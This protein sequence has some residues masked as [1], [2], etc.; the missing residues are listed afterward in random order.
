MPKGIYERKHKG[1]YPRNISHYA[2]AKKRGLTGNPN[3]TQGAKNQKPT[4]RQKRAVDAFLFEPAKTEAETVA[5][6]GYVPGKNGVGKNVPAIKGSKG[7][8][9]YLNERVPDSKLAEIIQLGMDAEKAPAGFEDF[10]P[11]WGNRFKFVELVAKLKGYNVT[12]APTVNV[13]FTNSIP[14][15]KVIDVDSIPEADVE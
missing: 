2:T 14:R 10:V 11:D 8:Q 15:P 12:V 4:E 1:T 13:Q 9:E 6:A 3:V 7:F 5:K